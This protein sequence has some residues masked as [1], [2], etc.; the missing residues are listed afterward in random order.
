[1]NN[2][3]LLILNAVIFVTTQIMSN[4]IRQWNCRGFSPNVEE[5]SILIDKYNPVALCLQETFLS[6]TS[7]ESLKHHT[8][9]PSNL[10]GGDRIRG[11]VA[12][13]VNNTVPHRTVN[14]NTS[15]QATAVSISLT[16]T[17]TICSVYLPPSIPIDCNELDELIEQLAKPFILMGDLNA[18]SS[19]WGC[20]DTNVK[21][22]QM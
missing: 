15:L 18:H 19:L 17:I 13:L 21:G 22:R 12:V 14:V 9:Y 7:K 1:M 11:V 10:N 5:L 16:K 3:I 4:N 6:D 8:I 2:S 20:R